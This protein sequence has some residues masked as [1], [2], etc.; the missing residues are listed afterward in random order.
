MHNAAA[1]DID[2]LSGHVVGIVRGQVQEHVGDVLHRLC[3]LEGDVFQSG[4]EIRLGVSALTADVVQCLLPDVGADDARADAVDIDVIGRGIHGN[5][6][7]HAGNAELGGSI[8]HI[9][10][11]AVLSRL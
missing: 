9:G 6:L 1:G 10:G 7:G 4:L 3:A 5:R 11:E 2:R 8:R